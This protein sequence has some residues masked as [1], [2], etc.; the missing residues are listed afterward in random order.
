MYT[1]TYENHVY[2][3]ASRSADPLGL[4]PRGVFY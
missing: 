4:G 3:Y 2:V 1:I